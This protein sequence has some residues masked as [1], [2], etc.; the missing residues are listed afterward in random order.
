MVFLLVFCEFIIQLHFSFRTF[1]F[2]KF[3]LNLKMFS[4]TQPIDNGVNFSMII[5]L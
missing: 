2:G 5:D 4:K 1:S 3:L